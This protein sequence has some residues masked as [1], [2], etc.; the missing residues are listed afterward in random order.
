MENENEGPTRRTRNKERKI[1]QRQKHYN[2][3]YKILR[4]QKPENL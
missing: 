3:K 2:T 4:T 1:E